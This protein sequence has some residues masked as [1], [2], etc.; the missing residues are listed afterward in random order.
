[1]L[2]LSIDKAFG[3]GEGERDMV[4]NGAEGPG[5]TARVEVEVVDR[6]KLVA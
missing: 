6:L 3:G 4:K 5:F 1:V 2:C